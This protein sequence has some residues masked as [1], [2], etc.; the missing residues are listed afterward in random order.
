MQFDDVKTGIPLFDQQHWQYFQAVTR[1]QR[2]CGKDGVEPDAMHSLL[3]DIRG[4]AV[5]NFDAEEQVMQV[6]N[7][8][9]LDRHKAKHDGFK[10]RIDEYIAELDGEPDLG[11]LAKRM[12]HLLVDWFANQIRDDD[13]KLARFLK[14]RG[15]DTYQ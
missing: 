5:D 10:D 8:P 1:L 6:E 7:Y 15:G 13:M 3:D 11:V 14:N 4:Y 12:S 2:L 9:H